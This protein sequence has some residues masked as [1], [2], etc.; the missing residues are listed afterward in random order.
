MPRALVALCLCAA[1]AACDRIAAFAQ[2]NNPLQSFDSRCANLRA[3]GAEVTRPAFTIREDYSR[4][5]Q[6]LARMSEPHAVNHRTVGLTR[7]KFGYR[8]SLELEGIEDPKTGRACAK[9][10]VRI[11]IEVTGMTV[12]VAREYRG[13]A[14]REP[15]VLE[16]EHK[17][18]AV[19][20]R[21]AADVAPTLERDLAARFGNRVVYGASIGAI[22]DAIKRE[23]G[24][25]LDAFME[26]SRAEI[27]R[28]HAQIDT[29][30]EY[31]KI[32]RVCGRE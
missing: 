11:D 9:P 3:G 5:Y 4:S 22:Q 28:R 1:L 19:F 7:A 25:H 20:E 21:Y 12:Y 31:E 17:H 10:R 30:D 13:D 27:D 24:G 23:L 16:H 29:A 8:S 6:D 26:R 2:S 14:C 18:V 15:L 32:S